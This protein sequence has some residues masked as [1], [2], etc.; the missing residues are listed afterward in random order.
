MATAGPLRVSVV[1]DNFFVNPS[2]GHLQ[3]TEASPPS[4]HQH[5]LDCG[6]T[7]SVTARP[8]G[9]PESVRQE[10]R[11]MWNDCVIALED[12]VFEPWVTFRKAGDAES[13]IM[14]RHQAG[15]DETD[16]DHAYVIF[17]GHQDKAKIEV[18]SPGFGLI[19][20]V[21]LDLFLGNKVDTST[22]YNGF[23][24][25]R[26]VDLSTIASDQPWIYT[27]EMMEI[28]G[29]ADEIVAIREAFRLAREVRRLSRPYLL[30]RNTSVED[31]RTAVE[32][33]DVLFIAATDLRRVLSRFAYDIES[34]DLF[35]L[36]KEMYAKLQLKLEHGS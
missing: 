22:L 8:E 36:A 28:L 12:D 27:D 21:M 25:S 4:A 30:T 14:A 34:T 29:N 26:V 1:R 10:I 20:Y 15:D 2:G 11:I 17:D 16:D 18:G 5:G 33:D 9:S 7:Q 3:W 13:W 19:G 32:D 23:M 35:R 31:V 24:P 6:C